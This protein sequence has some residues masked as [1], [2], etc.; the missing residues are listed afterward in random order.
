MQMTAASSFAR[1]SVTGTRGARREP[2]TQ[3]LVGSRSGTLLA[4]LSLIALFVVGSLA[5]CQ[6]SGGGKD[7]PAS[8]SDMSVMPMSC[9]N[10]KCE[11]PDS[12]CCD[13]EPCVDTTNNPLHCGGCGKAC[14]AREICNNGACV[15]RGG[16]RE[17]VC[18]TGAA[19]C[20][21][22]C[23]DA[24]SD[25]KNCGG[26]GLACREGE[27]CYM[28]QCK[29]GPSGISCRSG[30]ICCG[31]SCSDLQN[32]AKNCGKCGKTCAAGK[33]CKNGL[34]EGEC[35]PCMTGESCCNG[36]CVNLLNDAKNCRECGRDCKVVTGWETC[37]LGV[38]LFE[39]PD[40]GVKDM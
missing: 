37:I 9:M 35:L 15:C 19:C 38:C 18:P 36:V 40:G 24:Q 17:A 23:R 27:L 12:K 32:D 26:C 21:D 13:G 2:W 28:G 34:C 25:T 22:G 33:A 7:P 3:G 8:T 14:R 11:N 4:L 5:G 20:S 30:Q 39:Q 29:C 31:A 10:M 16:G 6:S 1:C